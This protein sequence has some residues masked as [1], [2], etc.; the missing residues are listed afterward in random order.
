MYIN[1]DIGRILVKSK[2]FDEA[3]SHFEQ[4]Q[5]TISGGNLGAHSFA[6]AICSLYRGSIYLAQKKHKQA[7]ENLQGY[8]AYHSNFCKAERAVELNYL[9]I[10]VAFLYRVRCQLPTAENLIIKSMDYMKL[11]SKCVKQKSEYKLCQQEL[12]AISEER[13]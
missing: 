10:Q 4:L 8:L 2:Q 5:L 7:L 9:Q 12:A 1:L 3:S 13:G 6:E 11:T